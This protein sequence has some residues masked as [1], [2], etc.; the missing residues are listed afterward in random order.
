MRLRNSKD[1][2]LERDDDGLKRCRIFRQKSF[3]GFRNVYHRQFV[4]ILILMELAGTLPA[5]DIDGPE[6]HINTQI[7][8]KGSALF[9]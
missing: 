9:E 2:G 7:G 5:A 3:S 4:F 8:E 6:P 1:D